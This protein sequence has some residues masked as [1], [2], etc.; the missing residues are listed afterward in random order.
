MTKPM[1]LGDIKEGSYIMI[2][3]SPCKVVEVEKSKPGKHGSAKVR[4]VGIDI[5]TGAKKSYVGP[6]ESKVDVPI[7][8]KGSGQVLS[9][10]GNVV[11]LMDLQSFQTLEA[12]YMEEDLKPKIKEGQE[13]EYWKVMDK[14]K[15]VRIKS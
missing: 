1:E 4:I 2:D 11:Q 3:N 7:I 13:V 8:E 15:I 12:E 14:I 5:F 10:T 6:S 9:V